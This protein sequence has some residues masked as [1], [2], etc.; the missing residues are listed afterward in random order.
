M[1]RFS[2]TPLA[3]AMALA[4]TACGGGSSDSDSGSDAGTDNTGT[5]TGTDTGTGTGTDTGT[6]TVTRVSLTGLAVKGILT[7]ADITVTSL[8]GSTEYGTTTTN[9]TG[10]YTLAEMDI[11]SDVPVK[12]TMTTNS[13]TQVKCDAA[14]GC[15]WGGNSYTF[16]QFYDYDNADFKLTAIL[17][18][19]GSETAKTLMVTPVT[20]LAATRA[21]AA[22]PS[23]AT[24][25][26]VTAVNKA[27]ATLLGLDNVD[28]TNTSPADITSSDSASA[29]I[30]SQKY[31]AIVAAI[32][33][34]ASRKNTDIANVVN[35]LAADYSD[36]G[37]VIN[38]SDENAVDLEDVFAGA[39]DAAEEAGTNL[40]ATGVAIATE[41][42]LDELEAS[43]AA[44]DEEE[45][46]E[47]VVEDETTTE[48]TEE[49]L[50]AQAVAASISLIEDLNNWND[51]IQSV[52][53]DTLVTALDTEAAE[54]DA[55]VSAMES[56]ADI[57]RGFQE[58]VVE[59][60]LYEDC[61]WWDSSDNCLEYD[62]Y[63]ETH[64]G[65]VFQ[66]T[67]IM[68]QNV[69]LGAYIVQNYNDLDST[70]NGD[71]S[72]TITATGLL[73][74]G[75]PLPII[76]FLDAD[77]DG[78]PDDGKDVSV[79]YTTT[80]LFGAT[81]VD[82]LSF[83]GEGVG[84]TID[85]GSA[86]TVS[87][88]L[89][90][91]LTA[92][93][94][95]FNMTGLEDGESF[96]ASGSLGL[97]FDSLDSLTAFVETEAIDGLKDMSIQ[98]D[99]SIDGISELADDT[100]FAQASADLSIDLT[101][102]R[103]VDG[104]G[105]YTGDL[106][107]S[108]AMGVLLQNDAGND[109]KIEGTLTA[110][111]G[112]SSDDINDLESWFVA[113]T[114]AITFVGAL[115]ATDTDG[116]VLTFDGSIGIVPTLADGEDAGVDLNFDGATK[117]VKA[118]GYSS[119][120]DGSIGMRD[121]AIL[122]ANGSIIKDGYDSPIYVLTEASLSG[123]LEVIN[124]AG[125]TRLHLS[126]YIG[127]N[128]LQEVAALAG[129]GSGP[130][131]PGYG[132]VIDS[133]TITGVTVNY[134]D[135]NSV[136]LTFESNYDPSFASLLTNMTGYG[137]TGYVS[138]GSAYIP[139]E[140]QITLENCVGDTTAGYDCEIYIAG[141]SAQDVHLDGSVD[142]DDATDWWAAV[143][144]SLSYYEYASASLT[145]ADQ[146][147]A[148][149]WLYGSEYVYLEDLL[150][151][152][153]VTLEI[154]VEGVDLYDASTESRIL[155]AETAETYLE[156]SVALDVDAAA[157]G[158]DDASIR[159]VGERTGLEDGI[160]LLRLKYGSNSITIN[161]D[162]EQLT[163]ASVTN[164]KISNGD[165]TM[166]IAATCASGDV[167]AQGIA[168]CDGDLEFAGNI[169]SGGYDVGTLEVRS[170]LPV[171]VFD[172]G[173][174]YNLVVTPAFMVELATGQ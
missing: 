48:P 135:D 100:D 83:S 93:I 67:G 138:D 113:D 10:R 40:G 127:A 46:A 76:D 18:S 131:D 143:S 163:T 162:S 117:L 53:T 102:S 173:S 150:A 112:G 22:Y 60:E 15:T 56:K 128:N 38:S 73:A 8:N 169:T 99:S 136:S 79:T 63:E 4:L 132:T 21:A 168:A 49:E 122:A 157:M 130:V 85:D 166:T 50:K 119:A 164:L 25:A 98:L 154:Y 68:L 116:N 80:T 17:P 161:L 133:I 54:T 7:G 58:L 65:V 156:Y 110:T 52:D 114:A 39:A 55:L 33:T 121:E 84:A 77:E 43:V 158:M 174:K 104:S 81:Y 139:S 141:I 172:D 34:V 41:Y 148:Q 115:Q 16:G 47:V 42:H 124:G 126:G 111:I 165:V 137:W 146:N 59:S 2:L 24:A 108:L 87:I 118:S 70:D 37:V 95:A 103:A 82:A 23:G 13:S 101:V 152:N 31:G 97:T 6:E 96:S 88:S 74:S 149:A 29:N 44:E 160:G 147:S 151:G 3:F 94:T 171:F 51:A 28:I 92:N 69:A 145:V 153:A 167:T 142:I 140:T 89:S 1:I 91:A 144:D 75:V 20:H 86:M 107:G 123:D 90:G 134:N 71:G 32:A 120:F 66:A 19:Y 30:D 72:F 159:L 45:V 155:D 105:D 61:Y 57:F 78:Q 170:G 62:T 12:V 64:P 36:G 9:A 5:D 27:T 26:E 109:D 106:Q 11:P 35:S 14:G 125:T 129:F